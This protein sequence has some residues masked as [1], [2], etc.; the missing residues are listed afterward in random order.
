MN[1]A[2]LLLLAALA[3]VSGSGVREVSCDECQTAAAKLAD[4]LLSEHSIEEQ[5]QIL[6]EVVCPQVHSLATR[7]KSKY[8]H[9]QLPADVDCEGILDMWFADMASCIYNHFILEQDVCSLLGICSKFRSIVGEWTCEECA[10][11]LA[12]TAEYMAREE[13]IAEGVSYLQGEC[14]CGQPGHSDQCQDLVATVIPMAMPVLAGA[15]TDADEVSHLCQDI[16][17]VC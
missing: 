11:I 10:D 6:K 4:H 8:L 1:Y 15:L 13:T 16:A 2:A 3:A 7:S 17:G 9:L 12:R 14:F 5:M